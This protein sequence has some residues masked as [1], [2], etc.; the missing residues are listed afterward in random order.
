MIAQHPNQHFHE[1]RLSCA[2]RS[3]IANTYDESVK[4]NTWL[5]TNIVEVIPV[6][7]HQ[8]IQESK[9]KQK[10]LD[11]WHYQMVEF[12]IFENA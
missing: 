12:T 2:T 1:R 9:W 8:P 5:F 10:E 3:E 11:Y 6:I 4:F 7:C